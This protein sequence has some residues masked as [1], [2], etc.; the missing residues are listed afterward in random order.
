[1]VIEKEMEMRKRQ[2]F[3]AVAILGVAVFSQG[4]ATVRDAAGGTVSYM[5]GDLKATVPKDIDAV[6]KATKKG[7]EELELIVTKAPKDALGAEIVAYDARN[8]KIRV[9][10]KAAAENATKISI[11]VGWFGSETISRLIYQKICDNLE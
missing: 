7:L 6:Y 1:L 8:K 10:L 2:V 11:R 9:R 4:C 3:L 5:R